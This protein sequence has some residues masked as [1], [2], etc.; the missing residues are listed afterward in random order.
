MPGC[1]EWFDIDYPDVIELRRQVFPIR[2]NYQMIGAPLDDLRWLDEVPRVRPGM[3]RLME[4]NTT[5]RRN[6]RIVVYRY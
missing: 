3:V 4:K 2:D 6:G 1:V 5:L